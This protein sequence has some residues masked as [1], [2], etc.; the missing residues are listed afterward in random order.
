V[1]RNGAYKNNRI[2]IAG[3]N[4]YK[5]TGDT[6]TTKNHIVFTFANIPLKTRMNATDTCIAGYAAS[7]AW[8]FLEDVNGGGT[9]DK[10]CN[11]GGGAWA[12]FTCQ[13][14]LPGGTEI[15]GT[16]AFGEANYDDG[17]K[18]QFPLYR[19]SAVGGSRGMTARETGDG[20]A[21]PLWLLP[22]GSAVSDITVMPT[23]TL[24]VVWA[25]APPL[26]VCGTHPICA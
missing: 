1:R 3:L 11:H 12:W 5:N 25:A 4:T 26:S 8:A 17:L 2:V 7:E 6:E 13:L 23:V 16:N 24:P 22:R 21:P 15:F 19:D 20:N 18:L 9:G 14:F 10:R